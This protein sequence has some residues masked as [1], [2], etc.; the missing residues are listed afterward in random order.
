MEAIMAN[1]SNILRPTNTH[2]ARVTCWLQ[3]G[4][5]NPK[6]DVFVLSPKGTRRTFLSPTLQVTETVTLE[7]GTLYNLPGLFLDKA[8]SNVGTIWTPD[9]A[10]LTVPKT[11][12][13]PVF[14][15]GADLRN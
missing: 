10:T 6:F 3:N 7:P 1:Y 5:K 12:I 14:A 13:Q 9:S 11:L 8:L 15:G 2:N 4:R